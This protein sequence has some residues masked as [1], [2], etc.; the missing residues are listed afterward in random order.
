M[1]DE[2]KS[3]S[4]L[5]KHPG[6]TA[7]IAVGLLLVFG[8]GIFSLVRKNP[9]APSGVRKTEDPSMGAADARVTIIEYGDFGCPTC[10][11]WEQT[12]TREKLLREY[13]NSVRFVWKDFP[14]ITPESP[15]AAE[16]AQCAFD[17]GKFWEY[18]DLLYQNA[19]SLG[20]GDLKKYA[21]ELG[22]N[23]VEFNRCL[24]SGE[25]AAKVHQSLQEAYQRGFSATPSFL[26]NGQKMIGPPSFDAFKQR[27]DGFLSSGG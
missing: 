2:R 10:R 12:G 1:D 8:M 15:K 7:G 4:I 19:P 26:I 11:A 9:P 16:A 13:G 18:H 5:W 14:I 20:L 27:I 23:A 22:L 17:Q 3:K 24:D 6:I 25:Y 21:V